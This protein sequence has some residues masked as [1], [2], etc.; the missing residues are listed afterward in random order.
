MLPHARRR[1]CDLRVGRVLG[2]MSA[3]DVVADQRRQRL[4]L[5]LEQVRR[6]AGLVGGEHLGDLLVALGLLADGDLDVRVGG[7]PDAPRPCRCSGTQDQKVSSTFSFGGGASV[8]AAELQAAASSSDAGRERPAIFEPDVAIFMRLSNLSVACA[9]VRST[10]GSAH[11]VEPDMSDVSI[12]C[13]GVK[14]PAGHVILRLEITGSV[15]GQEHS[16]G[17]PRDRSSSATDRAGPVHAAW[18]AIAYG[19][20]YNPEQWPE[21]VWAED[22]ALM[23]EAG[24]NLV[25]VGIFSWA[26]LE[27]AEGAFDFGWLDRV[28]DLLHGA[29]H[30]GRP[31]HAD[32]RAAGLVR[33]TATRTRRLVDRAGHVLGRRRPAELLPQLAG[34][35]RGRRAD[36][37][38]SSAAATATTRRW[39]CGTCTTSTAGVNAHCYC[40]TCAAAFRD[41]LRGRATATWTR[42]TPPGARRSGASATA[43]GPRSSR[44]AWRRPRSTRPSSS[45]SCASAPT[46]TWPTTAASATSCAGC[47]PGVP[48][49]TNFMIANC[50]WLDYWKWAGEVDIVS[51]D[52]YLRAERPD[53]HIEL[54]MSADLTRSLGRRRAVAADG[55][56]HQ[57]GQ[58]AA[59]ATS[60]S[61]RASCAATA[62][63]TSP[64][65]PTGCC[66]SSG[67]PRASARRSSTR[68]CCRTAAPAPGSGARSSSS[69][70]TWP[71][72]PSCAARGSRPTSRCVWD[73]E[74]WWALELDWRPSVDLA[75]R[76]R[77]EAYYEQLWR[78]HLT[79]D[80]VH[81]EAD[82]DRY[83][84]VVVPEPLPDHA[85]RGEEPR[86]ATSTA[87]ARC[88]CRTSP[89]SSTPTTRCTAGGVPG[90]AARRARPD[91]RGVPAA[92][93]R[94]AGPLSDGST[95]DVWAEDLR[96]AG[97]G[98]RCCPTWTVRRPAAGR[99]PPR[100]R[101]G[102]R[103]V[104]LDP[105]VPAPISATLLAQVYADAGLPTFEA[106]PD[107]VEIVRRPPYVI[108]INHGDTEID[109]EGHTVPA[110]A[111]WVGRPQ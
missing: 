9:T 102:Q 11:S 54:A 13:A 86:R 21:E 79:V 51:N 61:A 75:F 16:M 32:R 70:P 68:R 31:G 6:V 74:S 94:R 84:L 38:A 40:D 99:H 28:L 96:L 66:S 25:S 108:V 105:A 72:S 27:P 47:R 30:P 22:V 19:G 98:G 45:T 43:T 44:P 39:R 64:A 59:R 52:H 85:G 109:V 18:T 1:T 95:A 100:V 50:K 87:A 55:A 104:R 14:S 57:R 7:V 83:P 88:S 48:V 24:V 73:W 5:G 37:R 42:S 12:G 56:L 82:L 23:R 65:A 15:H 111:V 36:R 58:L 93:G 106:L 63:P 78:D 90:R 62:W 67:G 69:A 91:R 3:S 89:A 34:V 97:R 29:G 46:R 53:S 41:W 76:E 101:A 4:V 60:P 26:L 49:T 10:T 80:F 77:V 33:A 103:L 35:P 17:S 2:L 71:A 81:P 110:G 20:D 107:T 8:G 92:A